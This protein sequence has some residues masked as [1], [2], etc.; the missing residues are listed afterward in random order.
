[1]SR[2][3]G[4]DA[5][6]IGDETVLLYFRSSVLMRCDFCVCGV[7]L[8]ARPDSSGWMSSRRLFCCLLLR[9]AFNHHFIDRIRFFACW[10]SSTSTLV[11]LFFFAVTSHN[12][13]LLAVRGTVNKMRRSAS[14]FAAVE[15]GGTIFR[16]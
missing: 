10:W 3:A 12:T 6:E 5:I 4:R 7:C 13:F 15:S 1:M 14:P 11:G 8:F 9:V 2:S 16:L